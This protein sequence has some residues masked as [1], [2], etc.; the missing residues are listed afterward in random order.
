[1]ASVF[2]TNALQVNF[3]SVLGISDNDG[4]VNMFKALESTGLRG[5][6]GFPSVLYEQELEKF[7]D[8]AMVQDGD[9]TCVVSGKYVVISYDRFAG[10]FN[11]PNDGLI[12]LS[13][14][15]NHLGNPAV[16]LVEAKTFP[17]LK[18]SEKTV[19]TYVATNKT[20]DSRGESDELHVDKV[21][22]VKR[23]SVSKKK[24]A[25]TDTKDADEEPV[26]ALKRK[27]RLSVG[28][29]DEIV[30]KE[31]A[32]ENVGLQ[33]EATKSVDD[34]D[35]IILPVVAETTQMESGV[36]EQEDILQQICGD[37][38]LPSVLAAE[39]TRIKFSN[40]ISITGVADGDLY[41]SSLPKI[42]LT[43]KGK[44]PLV[45]VGIVKGHP[46]REIDT[47]EKASSEAR[48]EQ[49]QSFRGLIKNLRQGVQTDTTALSIEMHE[50]KKVFR[51]QNALFTKDLA[52]L[53]KEVK[54]LKAK[55]SKDFDDKLVVIRNDLLEF[56]VET[57]GQLA[58]LGTNLAE[59]ITFVTKGR[60]DKKG[61]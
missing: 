3:E 4:M 50:S 40:G 19:N 61:N 28:S 48:I 45:E 43:D 21:A 23:K 44:A 54:D 56:R 14:V 11:L 7:F 53:R 35:N 32:V 37:A 1:M 15:P 27:L 41:K 55:L 26:K 52:D 33:Q 47:R 2:I 34:V 36:V 58:S 5:F 16:T 59:L 31:P 10:V 60:D 29:D 9:I 17:S 38:L 39:P 24:S 18:I 12:D 49:D 57:Q 13:E 30:A 25:P 46:A 51:A 42:A 22:T 8:T 20:I 6:Q